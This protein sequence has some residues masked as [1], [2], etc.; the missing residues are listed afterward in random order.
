MAAPLAEVIDLASL[1]VRLEASLDADLVDLL[2]QLLADPLVAL[3]LASGYANST[4][5]L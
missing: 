3:A 5:R 4:K 2:G 1:L